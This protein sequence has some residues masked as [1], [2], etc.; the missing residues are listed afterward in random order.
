MLFVVSALKV[1]E[2]ECALRLDCV[3]IYVAVTTCHFRIGAVASKRARISMLRFFIFANS[4]RFFESDSILRINVPTYQ[5]VLCT[6]LF[7]RFPFSFVCLLRYRSLMFCKL[8]FGKLQGAL[9]L[10][11]LLECVIIILP[12]R[13]SVVNCVPYCW[14]LC[15]VIRFDALCGFL[16]LEF[17][18]LKLL[19]RTFK[20]QVASTQVKCHSLLCNTV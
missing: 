10:I 18:Q 6:Q 14:L 2:L 1:Y 7:L 3:T 16:S 8:A 15:Y 17:H 12:V 9:W 19:T 11:V 4:L 5:Y 13:T 20:V